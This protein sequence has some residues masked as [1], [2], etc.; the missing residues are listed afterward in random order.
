MTRRFAAVTVL[1]L[2]LAACGGAGKPPR[3]SS[4][5]TPSP[6]PLTAAQAKAVAA[7]GV[8]A[9]ADLPGYTVTAEAPDPESEKDARA[10]AACLGVTHAELIASDPGRTF[11]KG[12][13]EIT[14]S[15]DVAA[16]A[17][18]ARAELTAYDSDKGVTC[19]K[20][21]LTGFVSKE[22][23]TVRKLDLTRSQI[24]VTGADDAFAYTIDMSATAPDG[25][26]VALQGYELGALA[27]QAEVSLSVLSQGPPAMTLA[28]ATA[29][30]TTSVSRVK[31]AS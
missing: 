20:T 4:S 2:L 21:Q 19:G 13:L 23:L 6:T 8:L 5:P 16:D 18:A 1:A 15:V 3:A 25:S 22:G 30:L 10:L 27:G 9:A 24:T 29:L 12:P 28:D 14:S 17:T 31:D 11:T 7:V 26:T